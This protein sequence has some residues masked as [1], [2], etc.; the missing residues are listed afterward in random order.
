MRKLRVPSTGFT[1]IELM[2]VVVI[3]AILA[4]IALP[5]YQSY[6]VRANRA[7]AKS[8]LLNAAQRQQLYFNDTRAYAEDPNELN[9]DIPERVAEHYAV[10][11][12]IT[13]I[14]PPTFTILATPLGGTIQA[15]DGALYIDNTGAKEHAGDPW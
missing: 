13:T 14:P 2:A 8:Y 6:T 5:A 1:V 9:S 10:S 12:S 15:G 11:F 3:V 7:L 4:M